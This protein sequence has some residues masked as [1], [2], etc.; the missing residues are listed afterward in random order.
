MTEPKPVKHYEV[1][2]QAFNQAVNVLAQLPYQQVAGVIQ[3]L[4][5]SSK[6]VFLE[7][8]GQIVD[9]TKTEKLDKTDEEG[10]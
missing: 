2:P 6:A 8:A 3:T 9:T 10:T 4:T 7:S 1:Q 5:E